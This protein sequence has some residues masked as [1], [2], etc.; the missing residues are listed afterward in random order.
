MFEQDDF[1][2]WSRVTRM[3][4]SPL[5]RDLSFPYL[6]GLTRAP[7]DDFPG[8]GVAMQPYMT[9]TNFRNLWQ[10]WLEYLERP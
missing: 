6:M 3:A 2:N 4:A 7:L 8:P 1:D 9:E 5:C 10:T